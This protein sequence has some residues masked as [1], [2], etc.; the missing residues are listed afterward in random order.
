M[1]VW[2]ETK[3]EQSSLESIIYND[4]Q[5]HEVDT[6]NEEREHILKGIFDNPE[7]PENP[8]ITQCQPK[9]DDPKIP[10]IQSVIEE[11]LG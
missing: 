11:R 6:L 1:L 7:F 10:A 2:F 3:H 4:H 8:V 5:L 9:I